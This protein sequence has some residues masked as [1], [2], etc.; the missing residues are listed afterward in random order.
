MAPS[1]CRQPCTVL[2]CTQQASPTGKERCDGRTPALHLF[3][4]LGHRR[5]PEP[6]ARQGHLTLHQPYPLSHTY[7]ASVQQHRSRSNFRVLTIVILPAITVAGRFLAARLTPTS[8]E[9]ENA[10]RRILI[11]TQFSIIVSFR[12][13]NRRRFYTFFLMSCLLTV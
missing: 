7:S 4:G 11:F 5:T 1:C 3:P 12:R 8:K 13:I 9:T 6:T 2:Q 10:C